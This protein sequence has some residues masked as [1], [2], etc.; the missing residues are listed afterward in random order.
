MVNHSRVSTADSDAAVEIACG[1][2]ERAVVAAAG[3]SE[4]SASLVHVRAGA[5]IALAPRREDLVLYSLDGTGTISYGGGEDGGLRPGAAALV[6]EGRTALVT[7]GSGGLSIVRLSAGA[8]CDRHAPLGEPARVTH[9]DLD[10]RDRASGNRSF[11]VLFDMY[12]GSDRA[13]VFAGVVPPGKAPWHFHQYDEI[14]WIL[15]G[16]GLYH[17]AG[18]VEEFQPGC[19]FRVRPREVHIVENC[20]QGDLL[21]LGMFT[22]A[23]S[24]V[25]AYL[26]QAPRERTTR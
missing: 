15:D 23:G 14:V 19:A 8:G 1:A 9:L 3:G 21:L 7:G 12:N 13:T 10:R 16:H 22:P 18:G 17:L 26:A 6:P 11:Q 20:G 2:L 4:L 25:A 5:Q 24:P